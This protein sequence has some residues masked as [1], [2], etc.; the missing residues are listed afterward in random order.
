MKELKIDKTS[1]IQHQFFKI[2]YSKLDVYN[3]KI[4]ILLNKEIL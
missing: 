1:Y 2:S 3:D 4:N